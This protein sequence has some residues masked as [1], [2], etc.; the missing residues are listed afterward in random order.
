MHMEDFGGGG[1]MEG[2]GRDGGRRWGGGG[3]GGAREGA[4]LCEVYLL[5]CVLRS[6]FGYLRYI[7]LHVCSDQSSVI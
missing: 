3:G 7:Y 5:T 4:C 1:E 2:G 6:E